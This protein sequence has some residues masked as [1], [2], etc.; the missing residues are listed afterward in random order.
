MVKNRKYTIPLFKPDYGKEELDALKGPFKTSWIG[1]C[2]RTLEFETEF[3]YCTGA[4]KLRCGLGLRPNADF[5]KQFGKA[6]RRY[7]KNEWW[8]R[9]TARGKPAGEGGK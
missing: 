8:W 9:D 7:R 3:A 2:P 5:S 6:V 1:L 4:S